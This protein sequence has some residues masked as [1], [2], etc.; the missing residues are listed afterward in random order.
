VRLTKLERCRQFAELKRIY[1][2]ANP[3]AKHGGDRR[4]GKAKGQSATGGTLSDWYRDMAVRSG[5]S[6]R[7]I[8]RDAAIGERLTED[9]FRRLAGTRFDDNQRNLEALSRETPKRQRKIVDAWLR[10]EQT[11]APD[12]PAAIT[13]LFGRLRAVLRRAFGP[14]EDR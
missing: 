10:D 9:S 6:E 3:T 1:M 7:S 11:D 2:S 13:S 8:Q 14:G 4:S 12:A 5:C